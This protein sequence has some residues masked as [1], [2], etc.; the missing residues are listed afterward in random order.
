MKITIKLPSTVQLAKVPNKSSIPN[1]CCE[2]AIIG[3]A[4]YSTRYLL[5]SA[6]VSEDMCRN[7]LIFIFNVMLGTKS[8]IVTFYHISSVMYIGISLFPGNH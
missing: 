4:Y 2:Y 5:S 3:I 6:D 8:T 1:T 7:Q